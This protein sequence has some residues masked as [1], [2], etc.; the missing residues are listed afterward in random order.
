MT[1]WQTVCVTILWA[2]GPGDGRDGGNCTQMPY[3]EK[4]QRA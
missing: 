2:M 1:D 4:E 3:T